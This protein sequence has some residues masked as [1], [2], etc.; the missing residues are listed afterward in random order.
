MKLPIAIFLISTLLLSSCGSAVDTTPTIEKTPFL[1]D[2]YTVGQTQTGLTVEKTG[3]IT[4]SSSL[5]LTAQ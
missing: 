3:R 5:T 2:T 4:A 1:I